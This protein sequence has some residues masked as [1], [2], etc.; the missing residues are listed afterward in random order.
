MSKS[1]SSANRII[2]MQR[3]RAP[4]NSS[5]G[6]LPNKLHKDEPFIEFRDVHFRY[7]SRPDV[8]VL[9]GIDF[10][11]YAGENISIVGPSGCGKSTIVSLIERFYDISSGEVFIRGTPLSKLDITAFRATLGL[12]SQETSLYDGTIRQN[13]C[14]GVEEF[15]DDATII[16][17]CRDANIHDFISSLPDG[18]GTECGHGGLALSGGQRQRM[19]IA[20]ALLRNPSILLL[21]EATSALDAES[22]NL[23]VDALEKAGKGRTMI[24]ITHQ[25]EI[26]RRADKVLVIERGKVV[27]VGTY[28][29]LMAQKGW[30]WEMRGKL[31]DG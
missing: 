16:Q 9:K 27:E 17:A 6:I 31:V 3:L 13:L 7:P 8:K 5:T 26:M 22:R 24:S 14:L 10:K 18:Y 28:E 23:V 25:E 29:G 20:R 4:I 2:H 19:A 30:F 21:D 1:Q 12:V 11:I 15:V